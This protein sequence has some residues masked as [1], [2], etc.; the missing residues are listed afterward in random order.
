MP[1][2]APTRRPSSSLPTG[3]P[4]GRQG[5]AGSSTQNRTAADVLPFGGG[6]VAASTPPSPSAPRAASAPAPPA[7]AALSPGRPA[8]RASRRQG[9]GAP[10]V[11]ELPS[12]AG[13]S[14][15]VPGAAARQRAGGD[16]SA[17]RGRGRALDSP[18]GQVHRPAPRLPRLRPRPIFS[19]D[20]APAIGGRTERDGL[21]G[22]SPG[23]LSP[24]A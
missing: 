2:R 20:P 24:A 3:S 4:D 21:K 18:I 9:R 11:R 8:G 13:R 10:R 17:R 16:T 5:S 7:A 15:A 6:S 12:A 14:R 19:C 22:N 23:A 1:A